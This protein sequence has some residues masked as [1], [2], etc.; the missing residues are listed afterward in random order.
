ME[1]ME[2]PLFEQDGISS[3]NAHSTFNY[4]YTIQDAHTSNFQFP[5]PVFSVWALIRQL[6]TKH[7]NT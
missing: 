1:L 6:V 7:T 2:F 3:V 5:I 4:M